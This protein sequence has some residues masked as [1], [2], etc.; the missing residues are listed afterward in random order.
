[1]NLF[2]IIENVKPPRSEGTSNTYL[3]EYYRLFVGGI[4]V[5]RSVV[6][7]LS[8]CV[9][10]LKIG[11]KVYSLQQEAHHNP[12]QLY[13]KI[14]VL[15]V[16]LIS[17]A[18][19]CLQ[20]WFWFRINCKYDLDIWY[21]MIS[22]LIFDTQIFDIGDILVDIWYSDIW[23]WWYLGWYL[24]LRYLILVISWLIF[25]T[26]IFDIGDILVDIWYFMISRLIFDTQI[27]D[28]GDI[29]VTF[30]S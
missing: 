12:G 17:K 29:S 26:Q 1:M 18:Y 23:Y 20:L 21:L 27:F 13:H 8:G 6:E 16:E 19:I 5:N 24:I 10:G 9:R 2:Y 28:I 3:N 7:Q 30:F 14:N 11:N 22:W 15:F 25:D 4:P